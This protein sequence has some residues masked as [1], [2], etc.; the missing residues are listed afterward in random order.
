[1]NKKSFQ[2]PI[3]Q[4]GKAKV[5]QVVCKKAS[6]SGSSPIFQLHIGQQPS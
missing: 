1:M 2:A 5:Y 4:K 6:C 3:M